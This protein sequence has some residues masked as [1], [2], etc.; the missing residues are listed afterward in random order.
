MSENI[1]H[2]HSHQRWQIKKVMTTEGRLSGL[3]ATLIILTFLGIFLLYKIQFGAEQAYLRN[4]AH[5]VDGAVQIN[6]SLN[7]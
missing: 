6:S 7:K 2:N 4:P 5:S 3:Y 1:N